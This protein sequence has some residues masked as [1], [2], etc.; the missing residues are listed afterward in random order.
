M[1]RVRGSHAESLSRGRTAARHLSA[2]RTPGQP[3]SD[4]MKRVLFIAYLFP[5]IANSGTQRS[6]KFVKYLSH[7]GWDP[8]VLTAAHFDGHQIDERLLDEIPA[9]LRVERVPMLNERIGNL[10]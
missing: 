4:I 7:H 5:P 2:W 10:I 8:I 3:R 9:G 6:L 1:G